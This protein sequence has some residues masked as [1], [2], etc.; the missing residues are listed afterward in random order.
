MNLLDAAVRY[1]NAGISVIPA[2]GKMPSVSFWKP[3]QTK[4]ASI[5]QI[6]AWNAQGLFQN[7]AVVCGQVSGGLV[8]IDCDGIEA[9]KLFKAQFPA[10]ANN[11]LAVTSGS[12][13]GAHYWFYT[14][15]HTPT[16]KAMNIPNV[17]NIE[18]RSD[19]TYTIAPPSIHPDTNLAYI[20]R[21]SVKPLRV[22][23]APVVSWIESIKP[24]KMSRAAAKNQAAGS[25]SSGIT[26]RIAYGLAALGSE[27]AALK[28]VKDGQNEAIY[29]AC[30]KLGSH[31]KDGNLAQHH[32]EMAIYNAARD[33]GYIARDGETHLWST[34]R[35]G[36]N[37]G[38]G[39]S[40]DENTR[41]T[42]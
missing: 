1:A 3:A 26:N 20:V 10:L 40:R 9:I 11:T 12:R 21:R 28:L 29:N 14:P 19:G 27:I 37:T 15:I 17:G 4:C 35:S 7:L 32:A 39:N 23:L 42:R 25:N 31:V 18:L 5:A 36:F 34:I 2:R 6:Q 16:T 41:R 38:M 33:I 8:I 13:R 22:S 24:G 30:L